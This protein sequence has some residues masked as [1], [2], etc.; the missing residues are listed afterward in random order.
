MNS[1]VPS[2]DTL[3]GASRPA[4]ASRAK[5]RL[6]QSLEWRL[7][8]LSLIGV[9]AFML[10]T[11]FYL[12]Y[13]VRF[14][15]PLQLFQLNV[16]SSLQYYQTLTLFIT[17]VWLCIFA[18][19]GLY[20]RQHLLAGTEEYALIFRSTTYGLLVTILVGFLEHDLVIAR[21]WLLLAWAF[22][23][24]LV[25]LGHF[26]LR[27]AAYSLRQRGYFLSPAIIVGAYLFSVKMYPVEAGL[28]S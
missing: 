26:S 20:K 14:S 6:S 4:L 11:A 27:R 3:S 5:P 21:A 24:L 10:G 13:S 18:F 15:L 7:F 1:S 28:R 25:V 22:A 23:F 2:I 19:A 9:D 8:V 16:E 17:P 12:A